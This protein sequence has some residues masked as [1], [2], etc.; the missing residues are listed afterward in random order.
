[1][2]LQSLINMFL[3]EHDILDAEW[4]SI[5]NHVWHSQLQMMQVSFSQGGVI[6]T[7]NNQS[8]LIHLW[9]RL[10]S[11]S[12]FFW[13]WQVLM[14]F[15]F[16]GKLMG[17]ANLDGS[18][19]GVWRGTSNNTTTIVWHSLRRENSKL[20]TEGFKAIL[21]IIII[22]SHLRKP[23]FIYNIVFDMSSGRSWRVLGFDGPK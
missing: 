10:R 15:L 4:G 12:T 1:M 23:N 16:S 11:W 8:Y 14:P 7:Y 21:Y 22:T 6:I 19:L 5:A 18:P 20:S 2:I 3:D 9:V 13:S 17:A